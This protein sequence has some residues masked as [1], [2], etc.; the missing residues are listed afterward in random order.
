MESY[1]SVSNFKELEIVRAWSAMFGD[2]TLSLRLAGRA[3]IPG[4]ERSSFVLW[5]CEMLGAW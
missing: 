2:C 3:S 5:G 1:G 4:I